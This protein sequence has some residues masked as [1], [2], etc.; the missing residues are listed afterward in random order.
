MMTVTFTDFRANMAAVLDKV[1][2]GENMTITRNGRPVVDLVS[3][4][5][6]NP[7]AAD[8]YA[9]VDRLKKQ[10]EEAQ[11]R[12][13]VLSPSS[14]DAEARVAELRAERDSW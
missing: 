2:G 1:E 8:L 11:Q 9:M 13:L 5:R 6:V 4:Q 3:H 7:R 12:P 14:H 10:A